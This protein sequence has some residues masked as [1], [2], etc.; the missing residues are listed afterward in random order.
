ME[1]VKTDEAIVKSID[2]IVNSNNECKYND[3][4][5][6]LYV[7]SKGDTLVYGLSFNHIERIYDLIEDEGVNGYS[8]QMSALFINGKLVFLIDPNKKLE[9]SNIGCRLSINNPKSLNREIFAFVRYPTWVFY[10][11]DGRCYW[12]YRN[13]VKCN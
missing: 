3:F 9:T 13:S 12:A 7:E 10:R 8:N 6:C 11:F 5:W 1:L 4:F 2:T